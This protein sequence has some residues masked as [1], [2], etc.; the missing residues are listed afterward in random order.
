MNTFDIGFVT[1]LITLTCAFCV[2]GI[3]ARIGKNKH[4]FF[5]KLLNAFITACGGSLSVWPKS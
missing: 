4:P 5:E 3:V 1:I 2:W